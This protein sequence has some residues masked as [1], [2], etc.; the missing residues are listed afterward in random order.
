MFLIQ[1]N[2]ASVCEDQLRVTMDPKK[3]KRSRVTQNTVYWEDFLRKVWSEAA[4][5]WYRAL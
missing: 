5:S 4:A 2:L 3:E 1:N